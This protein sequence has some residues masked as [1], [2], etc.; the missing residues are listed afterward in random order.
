MSIACGHC[1]GRHASVAEEQSCSTLPL[2]MPESTNP[3]ASAEPAA[4]L[5]SERQV[6]FAVSLESQKLTEDKRHSAESLE[7]YTMKAM[8]AY[9]T[10]LLEMPTTNKTA[11]TG[12]P[13]VPAG[14]YALD[15]DGTIKFYQVDKPTEGRWAGYT[16]LKVQASDET[17]PIKNRSQVAL[18]LGVI[19]RD[20]MKAMLDYGKLIGKCG[21]CGR[22]L[23]NEESRARG[24][25]PICA[26]KMGW[27]A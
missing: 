22:T 23:T 13:D 1:H 10:A 8:R 17:Y 19:A 24:I 3:L 14:R 7:A 25:G 16:F 12:L 26:G 5:A 2:E 21:H 11:P 20:P 9:I 4:P 27:A 18:I 6:N 15:M